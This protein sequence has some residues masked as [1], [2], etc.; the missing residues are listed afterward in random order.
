MFRRPISALAAVLATGA[1]LAPAA[2]AVSDYPM[3]SKG[4]AGGSAAPAVE[5]IR[6]PGPTVVVEA[7]EATGFDWGSAG[8]GA[9][10]SVA[11]VLLA[12]GAAQ[13]FGN[14]FATR[15]AITR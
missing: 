4:A 5:T 9:G 12:A 13:R 3:S 2:G 6:V 8:I 11:L 14:A 15:S 10:V 1:V 7:D